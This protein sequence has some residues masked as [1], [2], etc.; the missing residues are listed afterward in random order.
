MAGVRGLLENAAGTTHG[1]PVMT[2]GRSGTGEAG[3]GGR[4]ATPCRRW[5]AGKGF[6]RIRGVANC[7]PGLRS[8]GVKGVCLGLY[9]G[10]VVTATWRM[11]G[12]RARG[13]SR[14]SERL[15][16]WPEQELVVG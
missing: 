14:D 11:N 4:R 13:Q 10:N 15:P 5:K 7:C 9:F 2:V 6:R 8:R 3:Q 16:Q 1:A 12:R